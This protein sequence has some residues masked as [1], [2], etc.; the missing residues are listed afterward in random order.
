MRKIKNIVR[1]YLWK[2]LKV[3]TRLKSGLWLK[4]QSDSDFSVFSE[5][6][7][8]KEYDDAIQFFFS[9][10]IAHPLILDLGANVGY[11]S[12][13]IADEL[14]QRNNDNFLIY[15]IEASD[16]NYSLL[17]D[18]INQPLLSN[19][20]IATHGL[21]GLKT[22]FAYLS[23]NTNHFGFG[24]TN[25]R[26]STKVNYVNIENLINELNIPI[27]IMK[28][29]IEGSEEIF[30]SQY[31]LLLQ[32]V[33]IAVIE[34][35]NSSINYDKCIEHLTQAGLKYLKTLNEIPRYKTSVQ[36][37]KRQV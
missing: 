19:K 8:N 6:F 30:L 2:M 37:F 17:K 3:K 26:T 25:N 22:G 15:S 36:I 16:S 21:A 5:I 7:L 34:F 27:S 10:N 18:R 11:F 35:H 23:T 32:K 13:R 4:I 29:D 31:P 20:I 28:C 24:I 14:L 1:N 12:L 33:N 9:E